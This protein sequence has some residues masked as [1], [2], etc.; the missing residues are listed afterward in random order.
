MSKIA[1]VYFSQS[2][3]TQAMAQ[4]VLEGIEKGGAQGELFEV[5]AIGAEEA[6]AFDKLALGCPAMGS[7]NLEEGDFEPFFNQLQGKLSGKK[8][9]LFGSYGWGDG[10]WMRNW[11]AQAEAAGAELAGG[12]GLIINESP[13][14]EGLQKCQDLGKQLAEM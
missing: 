13:D 4:A 1:V 2:G 12:E 10:E 11:Q 3:N 6:A 7:E 9:A 5:S 8:I 14:A